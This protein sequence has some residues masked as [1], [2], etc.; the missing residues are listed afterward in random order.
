MLRDRLE[1]S[2]KF[3][4]G[5]DSPGPCI[6]FMDVCLAT[7]STL[8]VLP[9]DP[10]DPDDVDSEAEDHAYDEVRYRVLASSIRGA[11]NVK[12]TQPT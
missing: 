2:L 11:T 9:R 6:F 4:R 3:A 7:L 1:S 8:P 10:K 12:V 5:E